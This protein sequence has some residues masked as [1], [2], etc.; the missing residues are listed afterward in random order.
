MLDFLAFLF[1]AGAALEGRWER[2]GDAFAGCTIEVEQATDGTGNLRGR[3]LALP[4][5][6]ARAGWLVGDIKWHSIRPCAQGTWQLGDLRKHFETQTGRVVKVD[7]QNYRATPGSGGLLRLH[8][9]ILPFFPAQ[10]WRRV[11]R[12]GP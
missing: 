12:G 4:E 5:P 1:P 11:G 9:G 8:T 7:F 6:M 2:T 10:T 3:I